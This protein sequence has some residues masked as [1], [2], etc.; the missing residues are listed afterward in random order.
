[1]AEGHYSEAEQAFEKL[2]ELQ[3]GVAEVH[4]NLGLIY[5]QERKYEPAVQELGRALK[6]KPGLQK[7]QTLLAI[8]LSELGR[9]RDALTGLEKAFHQS[10]DVEAKRMCGLQLLR[11]YA[12]LQRDR[13]AVEVALELNRMYPDDPE[14]LYHTGKVYGNSAFRSMERLAKVAPAS[15]WRHQAAAE[16][17]ESQG[18]YQL[19]L[20]EYRQVLALDPNRPGI[21]YR[22]GRTLMARSHDKTSTADMTAALAEFEQELQLDPINGNAAY[23]IGDIHRQAGRFDQAQNL[24]ERALKFYPDFEEAHTGLASVLMSLNKPE[25]ALLHL[26]KAITLDP[27]DE[28]AWYRLAQVQRTLG[29]TAEQQKASQEFARLRHEF[30]QQKGIE[31]V[32]SPREVTKQE[33]DTNAAQ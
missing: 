3:P 14:V 12:G 26:Q 25:D 9:Y 7:T 10:A 21:H 33:V 31:P 13:N 15:V 19:A 32:F 5:F 2:R 28:V 22:V 30:N 17:Y 23:E 29:N 18:S 20:A 27:N 8:A 6:L 16:V 1:L 24:F 11:A 4:A